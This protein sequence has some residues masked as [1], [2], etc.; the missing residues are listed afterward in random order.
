DT[1]GLHGAEADEIEREGMARARAR[2]KDASLRVLVLDLERAVSRET[3]S[4]PSALDLFPEAKEVLR[5][6]D[7]VVW[8]KADLVSEAASATIVMGADFVISARTGKGLDALLR[9]LTERAAA[10][11]NMT[12]GALTRLRHVT[13]VE[14]AVAGLKRA[15]E[16]LKDPAKRGTPELIAEDVRLAARALGS[17]TGAVGAED[18]LGEIFSS[19]CIGK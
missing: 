12:D 14:D 5:D 10:G 11:A 2:A 16:G 13:A 8:N 15:A 4:T 17:I 3:A 6:D 18:V 1:A 9:T 7:I 19:F